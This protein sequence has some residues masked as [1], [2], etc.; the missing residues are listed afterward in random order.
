M[1]PSEYIKL[2]AE[3]IDA[4]KGNPEVHVVQAL[5]DMLDQMMEFD[6]ADLEEDAS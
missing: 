1:K 4:G 6:P 5:I 3:E 2:R